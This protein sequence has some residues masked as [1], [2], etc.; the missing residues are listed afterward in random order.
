M[1]SPNSHR[2]DAKDDDDNDDQQVAI[3]K[4]QLMNSRAS[5]LKGKRTAHTIS[6]FHNGFELEHSGGLNRERLTKVMKGDVVLAEF[7]T[8]AWTSS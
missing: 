4:E 8:I 6:E 1:A 7:H 3:C 5:D 2:Y